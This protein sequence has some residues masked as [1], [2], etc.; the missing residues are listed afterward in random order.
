MFDKSTP[1]KLLTQLLTSLFTKLLTIKVFT[2]RTNFI[3]C[4]VY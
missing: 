2:S 3:A 1:L 4:L